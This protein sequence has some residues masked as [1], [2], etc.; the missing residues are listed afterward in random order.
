MHPESRIRPDRD[1][2]NCEIRRPFAANT[3]FMVASARR[4]F[5]PHE[6]GE[7]RMTLVSAA[8]RVNGR[9]IDLSLGTVRNG[10]RPP[11][12]L[13]P[14]ALAVLKLFL[15]KP[16]ALVSKDELMAAVWPG[17]A[18]TDDSLVKC[19]TELRK[20]LGDED[21]TTIKTV[22]KRGYVFELGVQPAGTNRRTW[23]GL[24]AALTGVIVL[25]AAYMWPSPKAPAVRE[26]SI[27]V[28]PF[29]NMSGD[30]AQDYLGS[31]IAEDIITILSSD[32]ALRVVSR[33]SSFVYDKP[34][35]VQR[36]GQDLKVNYVIE[37]SVRRAGD[38][39]RVTAQLIDAATG[40]H[41]WVDRYDEESSNVVALQENVA[42]KIHDSLAGNRGEIM[43]QEYA[44][45]W[46]KSAPSLEE[47]DYYLRGHQLFYRFTKEDNAKARQIFQ[48][49][50]AKFPGSALLRTGIVVTL[51][52]DIFND[53]TGDPW[54]DTE[55]AWKLA[56]EAE[57]IQDKSRLESLIS[58]WMMAYVY[59]LHEGDFERSAD[60][61]EAAAKLVPNDVFAHAGLAQFLT[62]AGRTDL[63]IEWMEEAVRRDAGR[64]FYLGDLAFAYYNAGRP[65]DAVAQFQK[66]KQP[67][68]RPWKL[69][70]AAT[71]ARLGKL[72]EARTLVAQV[73][74]DYP[75]WT[76]KD[77]AVWPTGVQPRYAESILKPYLADLAKA[78]LPEN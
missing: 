57:A 12:V 15:A 76:L 41:V 14:Q 43:K 47:Y 56:K 39:V 48:E 44:Q 24:A 66:M 69:N 61:A 38:T 74:K 45:A 77:E 34:V 62:F 20:A 32:P 71:Y 49:G 73:A 23:L 53:F 29:V 51:T 64:K 60:E 2:P 26:P 5:F 18:V 50:L 25:A 17:I 68:K 54:R 21:H 36:V 13:R 9:D 46:S 37:G 63:A 42:N 10:K 6:N 22:S 33:T 65:V 67:L 58:H 70:L 8:I 75:G 19:V 55:M 4:K 7:K 16:G 78:G 3:V 72:D 30:P 59:S 31:G 52:H 1:R 35:N 28:L 27:A 11:A 40:E